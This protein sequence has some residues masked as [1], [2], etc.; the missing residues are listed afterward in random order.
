MIKNP[1][2]AKCL[3]A[4]YADKTQQALQTGGSDNPFANLRRYKEAMLEAA[5][6]IKKNDAP[7][8]ASTT[9][10]QL[11]ATLKAIRAME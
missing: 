4:V 11:S 10:E 2:W 1:E 9:E 6:W 7:T 8:L 3:Y 5:A